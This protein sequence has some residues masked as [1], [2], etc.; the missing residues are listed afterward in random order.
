MAR[1]VGLFLALFLVLCG[2]LV[3]WPGID[4][5]ASG[6]FWSPDRG[7]YLSGWPPFRLVRDAIPILVAIIIC[8]YSALAIAAAR[9]P[10]HGLTWRAGVFG[11]LALA[12]GPGLV[13]NL[14]FKDH[15]GRARPAQIAAFGGPAR[16][17]PAFVPSDQC[18]RNCSFPAGDPS[19]GFVLV[20]AGFLM[21]EP[22]PRRAALAAAIGLGAVI[23]L[24]RIA[25]GGHFLSD[26]LASGFLVVATTWLLHR[27]V[28]VADG[29]G[30]LARPPPALWLLLGGSAATALAVLG[31]IAW[32]DRPL[33]DQFRTLD[34]AVEAVFRTITRFGI[35]TGY[36]V[37]AAVLALG[38]VVAARRAE[39]ARRARLLYHAG[40]AAFVFVAVGGAGLADD[41]LKP[42]FGRARPRLYLSDGIFGFTWHGAHAAYWSFPSGHATTIV[43]LAAALAV[44]ERRGLPVYAAAALLVVASRIVLDEHYLSDV[45]AGAFLAGVSTWAAAAGFRR[46]GLALSDSP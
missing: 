13:V 18:G 44:V 36:L 20:A 15:W 22:G 31:S 46:A 35:A 9:R 3:L 6:L 42:V 17:T 11:L 40:R 23:G 30:A 10:W 34:P 19:V 16:F 1:R 14:L 29:L 28:V 21:R 45:I 8:L 43:A 27:W 12:V 7:F 33:A 39:P 37:I 4:L 5:A 41:I 24:V 26:V 25:Q 38:C 32:I 2:G